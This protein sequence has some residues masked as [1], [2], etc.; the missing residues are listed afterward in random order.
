[1]ADKLPDYEK[2]PLDET[3][4]G[5]QFEPLK[6]FGVQHLF[7]YW[8]RISERYPRI[9][10]QSILSHT[11]EKSELTPQKPPPLLIAQPTETIPMSRFWFLDAA[12]NHLIQVQ[13]DRF[14]RNWRLRTGHEDYP[15][16]DSLFA[17]FWREWEGFQSL[18]RD[19]K[20]E[21]PKVDQC[22]LTYV[23]YID[24][25]QI[26][27]GLSGMEHAFVIF[28][29]QDRNDFLPKP[30]LMK[31]ESAYALPQGRG[32][33]HVSASPIFR[34]RDFKLV[35]NF[36]L[37]ARGNPINEQ[38]PSNDQIKA[39]FDL[40]HEWIVRGFDELTTPAMHK[41]WGKKHG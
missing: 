37:S 41:I 2:H 31:W 5:I 14:I 3:V 29:Q 19:E 12:G 27:D 7:R 9:E 33:L 4:M 6:Q 39:W 11:I 15:R 28:E 21:G 1:M 24:L 34:H 36:T 35:V 38:L 40:A 10:E 23:N 26:K 16:Y 13:N 20:I 22:E 17:S 18:L 25:D 8:S 32:R 30:S